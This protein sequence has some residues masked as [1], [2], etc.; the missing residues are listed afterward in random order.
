[1]TLVGK[2][3]VL[4]ITAFAFLFLGIST[5]VF[6]TAT[7]WKDAKNAEK[8]KFD[9]LSAKNRDATAK[10]AELETSLKTAQNENAAA[11][12][13]L[14]QKIAQTKTETDQMQQQ[15]TAA[16][17][18][19][20]TAQQTAHTSLEEA[21]AYRKQLEQL[22]EQKL[23]VE[24]Q[25]NDFKIQQTELNDQIRILSRERDVAKKNNDDLRDRVARYSSMVRQLGFSDD[26]S[27][28]KG[29]ESPPAV[30]GMILRV[31]AQNKKVEI[32]IGSDDGLVVG[33]EL[34]VYRTQ[35]RA[36]YLGK[37]K[38]ISVD[39]DQSVG[40]VIGN[41]IQGKKLKEGDVVATSFSS[42]PRS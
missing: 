27:R 21:E 29:L 1:M 15:I 2:I 38:I 34:M 4:V 24:K 37:I 30:H 31:D 19:V 13:A 8:K 16:R 23:A 3:L 25:A 9:D 36:E 22:R 5:V 11:K 12:A 32:S 28:I 26:I 40:V 35:P 7:N 18:E 20:V 33:H 14:D 41:T 6:T 10:L 17:G 39:P 42:G